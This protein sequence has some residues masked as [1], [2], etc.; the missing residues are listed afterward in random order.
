MTIPAGEVLV[1]I[2][3]SIT[4]PAGPQGTL[5]G[6]E[7]LHCAPR[8]CASHT[9]ELVVPA[10]HR[11]A[12]ALTTEGATLWVRSSAGPGQEPK[13]LFNGPVSK[14]EETGSPAVARKLRI[15][16]THDDA[17]LW[18]ALAWVNPAG[19][20]NASTYEL[21]GQASAEYRTV[22]GPVESVALTLAGDALG[23]LRPDVQIPASQG[24]GPVVTVRARFD[25]L[26]EILKPV[27]V[28]H[29][30]HL[31]I[32]RGR[33]GLHLTPVPPATFSKT[34]STAGGQISDYTHARQRPSLTRVVVG[35]P[36]EGKTR[37]FS[38]IV[39]TDA[40]ALWGVCG[41]GFVDA[42]D[43]GQEWSDALRRLADANTELAKTQAEMKSAQRAKVALDTIWGINQGAQVAQ[44]RATAEN[45][46]LEAVSAYTIAVQVRDA[47]VGDVATARASALAE[48]RQRGVDRLAEASATETSQLTLAPVSVW[49]LGSLEAPWVGSVL[50]TRLTGEQVTT[51]VVVEVKVDVTAAEGVVMTPALGAREAIVISPVIEALDALAS[52]VATLQRR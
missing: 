24:R 14:V 25:T 44:N 21:S 51:D 15:W 16:A 6:I 5:T 34:A 8:L 2:L 33:D 31:T 46:Y 4:T 39:D 3:V 27:L 50:R 7:E 40:E 52:R 43:T 18:S 23:R 48:M 32:E 29:G 35:G 30:W 41:E 38:R 42:R 28:E 47:A 1:D 22:T 45:E 11:K 19:A 49:R 36:G 9:L 13:T 26:D 10:T 12:S 20:V 17:D 37:L